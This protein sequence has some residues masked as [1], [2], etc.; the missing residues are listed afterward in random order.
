[1]TVEIVRVADQA[2]IDRARKLRHEVFVDEFDVTA[3]E[4]Y[5]DLDHRDTTVHLLATRHGADVGT[6]RLVSDAERPGVVH[7]TRVAVQQAARR[8]GA[9]RALMGALEGIALAEFGRGDPPRVRVELSVMEQAAP[10]YR[11]LGYTV[12]EDR[13]VEVRIWHRLAHKE[14]QGP[15]AGR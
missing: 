12:G 13:H 15:L 8:S 14:L 6:A 7:I 3:D 4:E 2:G 10:F 11:A 5:D 1:V 9:G